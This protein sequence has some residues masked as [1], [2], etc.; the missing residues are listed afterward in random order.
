MSP[1]MEIRE[2]TSISNKGRKLGGRDYEDYIRDKYGLSK[3]EFAIHP[4]RKYTKV[5][6][7]DAFS[8]KGNSLVFFEITTSIE[9]MKMEKVIADREAYQHTYPGS[10]FVIIV[11]A[12]KSPTKKRDGADNPIM[13]LGYQCDA[14]FI[15][16]DGLADFINSH[17][18]PNKPNILSEPKTMEINSNKLETLIK[19]M[20]GQ[21]FEVDTL[22][23]TMTK[24]TGVVSE[25]KSEP[26]KGKYSYYSIDSFLER[27]IKVD[28]IPVGAN[29]L[30]KQFNKK[31]NSD[32]CSWKPET[33]AKRTE[34]MTLYSVN[35][36][37]YFK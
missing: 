16:E 7:L 17:K 33:L 25:V 35:N 20:I 8:Q 37:I 10:K 15:G 22:M 18:L 31:Y 21:N 5:R 3:P 6:T 30:L 12:V 34:G 13:E 4:G 29:C 1:K 14:V 9:N 11:K 28:T 19:L 36:K 23:Q 27:C 26:R 2:A 24:Y 32:L